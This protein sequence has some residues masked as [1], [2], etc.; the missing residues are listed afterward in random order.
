MLGKLLGGY[1]GH[2][3]GE[4]YANNGLKGTLVGAGAAAVARRG[5]GPLALLVGGAWVAKKVLNRRSGRTTTASR[6]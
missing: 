6:A 5:V 3:I 1:I 2:R 4:R